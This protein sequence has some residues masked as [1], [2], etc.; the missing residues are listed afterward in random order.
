MQVNIETLITE[1]F[2]ADVKRIIFNNLISVLNEQLS[3]NLADEI[4]DE[5]ITLVINQT[6]RLLQ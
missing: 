4:T 3:D 1:L 2:D 6:K 5:V